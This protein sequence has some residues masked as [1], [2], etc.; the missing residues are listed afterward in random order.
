LAGTDAHVESLQAGADDYVAKPFDESEIHARVNNLIRLRTQER[1]LMELQKEKLTRFMPP[2]LAELILSDRDE[3][4][5]SHRAEVTVAFIDLRGFTAFAET[6]EPEDVLGV[7]QE[8]QS[9]MGQLIADH[10]G[11][12]ERFSG[13]A[14]M[15]FFNDPIPAPN[16]AEQAVR[17]AIAMRDRIEQLA[18]KWSERGIDLGAGIGVATGFATLGMI[19]FEKRKDYAAIGAVTNLAARLC[20]EARHGQILISAGVLHLVKDIVRTE[21]VGDLALKGFQKAVPAYN[22]TGLAK[23][24]PMR[25]KEQTKKSRRD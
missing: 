17:L 14:I 10:H 18:R 22:V 2:Q 19:G 23:Q 20:V 8:Y 9:E 12:I 11:M 3:V 7:L 25:E 1:E 16:H 24:R 4:L 21:S 13:D 5:K 6:A 15:I